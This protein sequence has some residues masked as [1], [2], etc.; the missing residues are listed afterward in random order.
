MIDAM[1][2]RPTVAEID[3]TISRNIA[4]VKRSLNF[5]PRCSAAATCC[6]PLIERKTAANCTRLTV[7]Q[8]AASLNFVVK[9]H[10]HIHGKDGVSHKGKCIASLGTLGPIS[11]GK[12][13]AREQ[14]ADV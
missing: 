9:T 5:A 6:T 1:R 12:N 14:E 8:L 3:I 4:F 7:S 13:E 10:R 2:Y 11:E